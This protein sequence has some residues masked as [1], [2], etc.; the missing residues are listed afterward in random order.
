MNAMV[1][2]GQSAA[3]SRRGRLWLALGMAG[4]LVACGGG[5]G[6][7]SIDPTPTPTPTPTPVT[8]RKLSADSPVAAGCTGGSNTGTLYVG[9]EVEPMAASFAADSQH[10]VAVWQQ[11]RWSDGGARALVSAVSTDGGATWQRSLQPMSRCG[12]AA[13]GSAGDFERVSDPW[14]DVA[15]DGVVHLV[16]LVLNGG[17]LTAGSSS[18]MVASR[19]TDGGRT[20]SAPL[21]LVNN[22]SS[23]FNDKES[24]T[25]DPTDARKV[26]VV[27]DRLDSAGRGPAMLA[28]STDAGLSWEP[29]RPFYTPVVA[30]NP[31][32]ISQT[33]GNR[34]LVIPA[35]PQ[36]GTLVNFFT[37]IDTVAGTSTVR[38]GLVR[39]TDF[40]VSWGAPVFVASIQAVGAHD[41]F[42]ANVQIRDGADLVSAA[43]GP[44]GGL[45]LTWQDARF[46]GGQFDAVALSRSTDGGLTWS[47]PVAINRIASTSAFTPTLQVRADGVV[48]VLHYDLRNRTA[49][50]ALLADAWLLTSRDGLN[51]TETHVSGPFDLGAAPNA[52]GLFLGDYQGLLGAGADFV[53]VL[54]VS[55]PGDAGNRTDVF[56]P[57]FTVTA[58]AAAQAD[59]FVAR[60]ASATSAAQAVDWQDARQNA[61]VSVMERRI[62]GW[63]AR[64]GARSTAPKQ[65]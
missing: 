13:P 37:Q 14:I 32:G 51:W 9:A 22:D 52:R 35:G 54:V 49:G 60:G 11:D 8:A 56:S 50:S 29:A 6:G 45:W 44:D 17:V 31:A 3:R 26:Y 2:Q 64:V 19:S 18:G 43:V 53:P 20:W 47:A 61:I 63:A 7:A 28:R 46:S 39:S 34:V 5:G 40:G 30:A 10:M 38:A 59:A 1:R 57:R 24:V 42:N 21:T 41:P 55:A 25:A 65:R 15:S 62:P 27:W 12:G 58:A 48:G 16:G 36:R 33:V 4:W 23:L